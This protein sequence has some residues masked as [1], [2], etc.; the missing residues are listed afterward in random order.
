MLP[1]A[2]YLSMSPDIGLRPGDRLFFWAMDVLFYIR[3]PLLVRDF[4]LW[5]GYW[6]QP[7]FPRRFHEKMLW[8][9]L[10]DHDPRFTLLSD[11]L[12][13]KTH[14]KQ[15]YPELMVA[16][17]LWQGIDPAE[18]PDEI[19]SGDCVVKAN[20]GSGMNILIRGG[21]CDRAELM[22]KAT[23]WL[24]RPYGKRHHEWGYWGITPKVFVE[25]LLLDN[26][27]PVEAEFKFHVSGGEVHYALLNFQDSTGEVQYVILDRQG[28]SRVV[29]AD[30]EPD[31]MSVPFDRPANWAA[32]V[33]A[34]RS[35]GNQFDY[36]RCDLYVVE[37]KVYFSEV[38]FYSL[39]GYDWVGDR[40]IMEALNENWDIRRSWFLTECQSGWR[41]HYAR[42]LMRAL[43]PSST[44]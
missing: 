9:K 5:Q 1:F 35:L 16:N 44:V 25:K 33:E 43:E 39:G 40:C 24:R 23:R 36:I 7:S 2:S 4:H 18:I 29:L 21:E 34:A 38:T 10:F 12:A 15:H 13:A 32:L 17:T 6:P 42:R 3:H 31:R 11:K 19:L 27:L 22:R 28:Q 14:I 30:I 41:G 26:G 8:R 37:D 20:H